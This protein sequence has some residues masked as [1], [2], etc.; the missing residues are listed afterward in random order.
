MTRQIAF[1]LQTTAHVK[2]HQTPGGARLFAEL[3]IGVHLRFT[4]DSPVLLRGDHR[5]RFKDNEFAG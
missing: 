3:V 1:T 2:L 4:F 5:I